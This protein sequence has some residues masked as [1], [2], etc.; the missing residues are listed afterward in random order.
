MAGPVKCNGSQ[1][2]GGE[3]DWSTLCTCIVLIIVLVILII[4]CY[5]LCIITN[6]IYHN[7]SVRDRVRLSLRHS[8]LWSIAMCHNLLWSSDMHCRNVPAFQVAFTSKLCRWTFHFNGVQSCK[9][10]HFLHRSNLSN[11]ILPQVHL[12]WMKLRWMSTS[13]GKSWQFLQIKLV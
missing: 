11:L 9:I 5:S 7:H 3:I 10:S 13:E 12:Y 8:K 4:Y 2:E 6:I 1:C